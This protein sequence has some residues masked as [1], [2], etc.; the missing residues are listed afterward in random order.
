MISDNVILGLV[1]NPSTLFEIGMKY[2]LKK[3]ARGDVDK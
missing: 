2:W 3:R 1:L